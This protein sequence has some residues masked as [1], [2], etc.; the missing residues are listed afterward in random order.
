MNNDDK[1]MVDGEA[2]KQT[3]EPTNE[4]KWIEYRRSVGLPDQSPKVDAGWSKKH[5]CSNRVA[6]LIK[7]DNNGNIW[8]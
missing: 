3:L 2:I 5:N 7:M 6:R 4:E 1:P 8:S